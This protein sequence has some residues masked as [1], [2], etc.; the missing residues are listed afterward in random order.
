[1]KFSAISSIFRIESCIDKCRISEN[2]VL[3]N[4]LGCFSKPEY[5][6]GVQNVHDKFIVICIN[7]IFKYFIVK[8]LKRIIIESVIS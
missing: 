3:S 6:S 2:L 8:A 4:A 5:E 7:I 1:M